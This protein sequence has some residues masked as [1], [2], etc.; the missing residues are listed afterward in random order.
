[1]SFL[2]GN[3]NSIG[4]PN[5]KMF[6][7]DNSTTATHQEGR[8]VPYLAGNRRVGV[9]WLSDALNITLS[10]GGGKSKGAAG[11]NSKYYAD[12]VGAVCHG[13]VD[14]LDEV[15]MDNFLVW[16]TS[17]GGSMVRGS[18]DF[19]T[20]TINRGV[21]TQQMRFYWGTETQVADPILT[22]GAPPINGH[23]TGVLNIPSVMAGVEYSLKTGG[24]TVLTFV[25]TG[26]G[27]VT[28]VQSFDGGVTGDYILNTIAGGTLKYTVKFVSGSAAIGQAVTGNFTMG[29]T[30]V[31]HPPYSGICYFV[32]EQAALGTG[33]PAAPQIEVTVAR[34]PQ[35]SGLTNPSAI[36][37][38]INAMAVF[39]EWWTN[40]RFG[41]GLS[42]DLLDLTTL[43]AVATLI[44]NAGFGLSPFVDRQQPARQMFTELLQYFNGWLRIVGG[45]LQVGVDSPAADLSLLTVLD[46]S[47]LTEEPDL[48][49]ES[50]SQTFNRTNVTYS[51]RLRFYKE[52]AVSWIDNANLQIVG[53]PIEQTLAR[54]WITVA[55]VARLAAAAAGQVAGIPSV[56]GQLKALR[57]AVSTLFPGDLVKLAY[58][59]YITTMIIRLEE[60]NLGVAESAVVDLAFSEDRSGA[61]SVLYVSPDEVWA[62]EQDLESE[63]IPGNQSLI[64]ELPQGLIG[65]YKITLSPL[66]APADLVSSSYNIWRSATDGGNYKQIG[67]DQ[68]FAIFGTLAAPYTANTLVI[69]D[70]VS[71]LVDFD[72]YS[73]DNLAAVLEPD[74]IIEDTLVFVDGEIM[75]LRDVTPVS[76]LRYKLT[77]LV[78]GREDTVRAAHSTLAGVFIISRANLYWLRQNY[79]SKGSTHSFEFQPSI[80]GVPVDFST[81]VPLDYTVTAR[82]KRPLPPINIA[83][84]N[85]LVPST[86]GAGVGYF[87]S[88]ADIPFAWRLSSWDRPLYGDWFNM[89]GNPF[90]DDKVVTYI[91]I[92]ATTGS[93]TKPVRK[94]TLAAGIESATYTNAQLVSDFSGEPTSFQARIWSNRSGYLSAREQDFLVTKL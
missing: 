15:W 50:W 72:P 29:R 73:V 26:P 11:A 55:F 90:D 32:I 36:S 69:D 75:S 22:A 61:Q 40:K 57:N 41:L 31:N 77:G 3:T 9:T 70:F 19:I 91:E 44:T 43:N 35:P 8:P 78:R 83:I 17:G 84:S 27:P 4:R 76:T 24:N 23:T 80:G 2:G 42:T 21:K 59:D 39:L 85:V 28:Y 66:A 88:G 25:A 14:R 37:S 46:E 82:S 1:M 74:A 34:V 7:M 86:G 58:T 16:P 6:G 18:E 20:I 81:L 38:D 10:K 92:W 13:P 63:A 33:R 67:T 45:L 93:P 52:S 51:N 30:Q 79:F 54:T 12:L 60:K 56:T 94:I 48:K 68:N 89:W 47:V 87:N 71:M 5:T 64:V 49:P 65:D 62:Q 53:A